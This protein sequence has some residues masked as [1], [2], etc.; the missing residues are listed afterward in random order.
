M[1]AGAGESGHIAS[2]V[3][4]QPDSMKSLPPGRFQPLKVPQP[5][6]TAQ[7]KTKC[8]NSRS[9]WGSSQSSHGTKYFSNKCKKERLGSMCFR[10]ANERE[11]LYEGVGAK[12][13]GACMESHNR[14]QSSVW[15]L[16]TSKCYPNR[17]K[18]KKQPC[19]SVN[20]REC[21]CEKKQQS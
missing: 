14:T 6:K 2:E 16:Q 20:S 17:K 11:G 7:A 9:L 15:E 10:K 3:R 12:C 8:G 13:K 1:E 18:K 5:S 19:S 21:K 4:K